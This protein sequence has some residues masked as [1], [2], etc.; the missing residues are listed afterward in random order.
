MKRFIVW[1]IGLIVWCGLYA[2]VL[3]MV[4]V[5]KVFRLGE[6]KETP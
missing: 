1:L 6:R 3:V 2:A 4:L 5:F